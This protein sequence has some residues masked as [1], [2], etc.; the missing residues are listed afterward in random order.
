MTLFFRSFALIVLLFLA[1]CDASDPEDETVM[2][3]LDIEPVISGQALSDDPSTIYTL[4]G[5]AMTFTSARF[6]V[7]EITLLAENGDE[8]R[9]KTEAVTLPAKDTDDNNVTHTVDEQII[10][11]K[12]DTGQRRYDL[13]EVPAGT[14]TGIRYKVGIDGLTNR[15][16]PTQA[17][18]GHPLAIQTDKGNHWSWNAGYIYLRMDGQLDLDGDGTPEAGED[19]TWFVHLGTPNFLREV[20][21]S[22]T[23]SLQGGNMHDLHLMVDYAK[24]IEDVDYTD[25]EQRDCHTANNLPVANKV[26]A[27]ISSAFMFHGVHRHN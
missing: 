26:G 24:F 8:V 10:L 5:Q 7:S 2:L 4:N 9:V 23:F 22:T 17:P 11:F 14:Y 3:N 18:A 25:P 6:Y 12:H 16:D 27:D 19:A 21:L 1:A 20:E 15:V 13:G